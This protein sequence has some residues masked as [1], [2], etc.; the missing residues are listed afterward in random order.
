MSPRLYFSQKLYNYK[1]L[2]VILR[3]N[4]VY[5]YARVLINRAQIV[6]VNIYMDNLIV[7][8][9]RVA[10]MFYFQIVDLVLYE[11][12]RADLNPVC[13]H[14]HPTSKLFSRWE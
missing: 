9:E 8:Q 4:I 3:I 5:F 11:G 6:Q 13:K 7:Y 2:L 12:I 14:P 1:N 10:R